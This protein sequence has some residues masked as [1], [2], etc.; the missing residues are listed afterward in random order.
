MNPVIPDNDDPIQ[1]FDIIEIDNPVPREENTFTIFDPHF[2]PH[3]LHPAIP[4]NTFPTH[5]VLIIKEGENND[6]IP[7]FGICTIAAFLSGKTLT[8]SNSYSIDWKSC[9]TITFQLVDRHLKI[10]SPSNAQFVSFFL[11]ISD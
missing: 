2:N 11:K 7:S 10:F 8:K 3:S 6:Y 1:L 5:T 9:D 4:A